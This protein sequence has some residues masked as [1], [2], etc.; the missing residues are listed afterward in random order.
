MYVQTVY[1]VL[2]H[3][4]GYFHPRSRFLM[5]SEC[6]KQ[7]NLNIPSL[8]LACSYLF[9]KYFS[10]R[11]FCDV[12]L[13][14]SPRLISLHTEFNFPQHILMPWTELWPPKN[15]SFHWR[16]AGLSFMLLFPRQQFQ[17]ASGESWAAK[18]VALRHLQAS[19]H[20]WRWASGL[21]SPAASWEKSLSGCPA[22]LNITFYFLKPFFPFFCTT[23]LLWGPS[24]GSSSSLLSSLS[25][26]GWEKA[27]L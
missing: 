22:H 6:W 17:S 20:A 19:S 11:W 12:F 23:Q 18:C 7:A 4:C 15:H 26:P 3:R 13:S 5:S 9:Y 2:L 27:A 1:L 16:G 24:N 14:L 8:Y 21:S 10:L 25:W